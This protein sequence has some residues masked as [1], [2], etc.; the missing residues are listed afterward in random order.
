[1]KR[2]IATNALWA[3][4]VVTTGLFSPALADGALAVGSTSNVEKD[5]IAFG[6]AINYRSEGEA[7]RTALEYCRDYKPAPKAAAQCRLVG[8]FKDE[9]YAIAMD[10]KPGTPGAGWAIARS[11]DQA[12]DRALENCKA[13]AG[14]DRRVFCKVDEAKCD[15]DAR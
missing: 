14:R 4:L 12:E 3:T 10:P 7:R 2:M 13:T 5:G 6:T 8:T 1:M 9:C 15:G 11:K